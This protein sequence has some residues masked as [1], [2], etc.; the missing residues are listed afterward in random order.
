MGA[1]LAGL[2]GT[3]ESTIRRAMRTPTAVLADDHQL[4]REGL[5][6]LLEDEDIVVVGEAA[7]GLA[8][9]ELALRHRPDLIVLDVSM[10]LLGG[11]GATRRILSTWPDAR[12]VLLSMYGEQSLRSDGLAAGARGFLLKDGSRLDLQSAI[13]TALS[14]CAASTTP[15]WVEAPQAPALSARQ[16]QVLQRLAMGERPKGIA[17]DLGLSERTV[18][19]HI[20]IAY[21]RL[22]VT[23]RLDAVLAAAELGL[24]H[25]DLRHLHAED[26]GDPSSTGAGNRPQR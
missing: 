23:S 26:R 20:A 6:R 21:R 17:Q 14:P 22:H 10:P 25:L 5:R 16:R 11:I 12:V 2:Q 9:M 8:A 15:S 4:V 1:A 7:D 18:N 24:I 13:V 19:N 3:G